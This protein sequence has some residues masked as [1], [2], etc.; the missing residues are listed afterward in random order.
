M[1]HWTQGHNFS[2]ETLRENLFSTKDCTLS[3]A[4]GPFLYLQSS[5]TISVSLP[6]YAFLPLLFPLISEIWKF[7]DYA[8][9]F[10]NYVSS[11]TAAFQLESYEWGQSDM[12]EE[13]ALVSM[14]QEL[15][16]QTPMWVMGRKRTNGMDQEV[17]PGETEFFMLLKMV[18]VKWSLNTF[19]KY[20]LF[21]LLRRNDIW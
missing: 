11:C 9:L 1:P 12:G 18:L 20:T 7:R 10:Q 8:I 17:C 2:L 15:G 3:L 13:G 21:L 14:L 5:S 6:S 19:R 4:H 16:S